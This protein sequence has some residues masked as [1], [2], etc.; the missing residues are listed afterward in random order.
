MHEQ[1]DHWADV[2]RRMGDDDYAAAIQRAMRHGGVDGP[3]MDAYLRA[4][5]PRMLWTGWERYWASKER[6]PER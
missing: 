2:S 3:L 4:M 6:P 1:L 5:P